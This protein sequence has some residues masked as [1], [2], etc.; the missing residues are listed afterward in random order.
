MVGSR[1]NDEGLGKKSKVASTCTMRRSFGGNSPG[2]TIY[3]RLNFIQTRISRN[4]SIPPLGTSPPHSLPAS[5]SRIP[6]PPIQNGRGRSQACLLRCLSC[7]FPSNPPL[8]STPLLSPTNLLLKVFYRTEYSFALV[9]LKP[10]ITGH[11]LVCPNRV[12]ARL[13]DLSAAEVTD[14]F[15]TVQRI[16]KAVEH[17]YEADALNIAIQDG[18]AA[19]QS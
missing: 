17:I 1:A 19:G 18:V 13:K 9:N 5:R 6:P 11:V 15:L 10:L 3:I 7:H 16:G 8:H 14:L 2:R 4:H 12:V